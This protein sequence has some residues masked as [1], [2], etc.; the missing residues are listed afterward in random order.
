MKRVCVLQFAEEDEE[1]TTAA[2]PK[3]DKVP[4]DQTIVNVDNEHSLIVVRAQHNSCSG[5]Q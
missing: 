4:Y 5:P 3:K 2:A 1:L